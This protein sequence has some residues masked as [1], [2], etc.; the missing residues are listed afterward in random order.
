[1]QS[2]Q[3]WRGEGG[4]GGQELWTEY[5]MILHMY[6]FIQRKLSELYCHNLASLLNIYTK[7]TGNHGSNIK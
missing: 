7:F 5:R 1:M 6:R 3:P 2:I 4:G